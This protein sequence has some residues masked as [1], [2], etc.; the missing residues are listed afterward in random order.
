MFSSLIST[1]KE[2][3]PIDGLPVIILQYSA[4]RASAITCFLRAC[5]DDNLGEVKFI[6]KIYS[7]FPTKQ[8]E[9][10][11][12]ILHPVS[13]TEVITSDVETFFAPRMSIFTDLLLS[14]SVHRIFDYLISKYSI[15]KPNL[16]AEFQVN[17][18]IETVRR[19][20]N[21][22]RGTFTNFI[23][24]DFSNDIIQKDQFNYF[25]VAWDIK[26]PT[27]KEVRDIW[28]NAIDSQ[29]IGLLN[30]I[31]TKFEIL[32]DVDVLLSD[33]HSN[34]IIN[35][36]VCSHQGVELPKHDKCPVLIE[37]KPCGKLYEVEQ[38]KCFNCQKDEKF[39]L[40]KI[41]KARRI[42]EG[43][44]CQYRFS[45]GERKGKCCGE[46][47]VKDGLCRACQK[48]KPLAVPVGPP[49][50]PYLPN[51]PTG[52]FPNFPVLPSLPRIETPPISQ[53]EV[54]KWIHDN[55]YY[56]VIKPV[57]LKDFLII[58][59]PSGNMRVYGKASES[60]IIPLTKEELARTE[61]LGIHQG[62][63]PPK[64]M[65]P[66][67]R[68]NIDNKDS[69]VL[70]ITALPWGGD[71]LIITD[72]GL[73][74]NFLIKQ[75]SKG[76][77]LHGKESDGKIIPLTKEDLEAVKKTGLVFGENIFYEPK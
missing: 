68:S 24:E 45:R 65:T 37:G 33:D 32:D 31:S 74:N 48:K 17:P 75:D 34:V 47:V 55:N 22:S 28:D 51:L 77:S 60:E 12:E 46:P 38:G 76:V 30:Y 14:N 53:I 49:M 58:S 70:A 36:L 25:T 67:E 1:I 26:T 54:E 66:T 7:N 56:I 73:L 40:E 35:A 3:I 20:A 6:E 61:K 2:S 8:I 69:S 9:E 18:P 52:G 62:V 72:S 63:E 64:L 59:N 44:G 15:D 57:S 16:M 23:S 4:T 19:I 43:T 13:Q 10:P 5:L 27:D 41:E 29:S 21:I 71:Y 50:I 42:A 11:F 39:Q